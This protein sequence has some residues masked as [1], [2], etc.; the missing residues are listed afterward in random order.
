MR[1]RILSTL[2]HLAL[3]SL[4][5]LIRCLGLLFRPVC[6]RTTA[7]FARDIDPVQAGLEFDRF[8]ADWTRC[9]WNRV[10]AKS[11][12]NFRINSSFMQVVKPT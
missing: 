2:N 9:A 12:L 8:H 5:N 1:H 10:S 3:G 7:T 4:I 11:A 6:Q